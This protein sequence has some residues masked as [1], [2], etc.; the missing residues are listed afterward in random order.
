MLKYKFRTVERRFDILDCPVFWFLYPVGCES[1]SYFNLESDKCEL[2]SIGTYNDGSQITECMSCPP[3][4]TTSTTGSKS[5]DDCIGESL[6]G[7]YRIPPAYVFTQ[8]I[9][10]RR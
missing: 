8:G 3:H 7:N 6:C 2:C 9:G 4:T 10:E 5:S 1:G